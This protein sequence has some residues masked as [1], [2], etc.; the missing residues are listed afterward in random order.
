MIYLIKTVDAPFLKIG[1]SNN[2]QGR[3]KNIQIHCPLEIICLAERNGS[4]GL[5]VE[6][7][8]SCLEYRIRGE[9]YKDCDFVRKS[10]FATYDPYPKCST[11]GEINKIKEIQK[12]ERVLYFGEEFTNKPILSAMALSKYLTRGEK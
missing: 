4:P 11:L 1:F 10:F 5:E 12:I 8:R 9:W 6:I 3:Y 2:P 7:H